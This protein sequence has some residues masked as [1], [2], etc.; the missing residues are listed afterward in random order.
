MI[1]LRRAPNSPE[2]DVCDERLVQYIANLYWRG[3]DELLGLLFDA[4][5]RREDVVDGAGEFY[6]NLLDRRTD[7]AMH[8][9][10]SIPAEKQ[11]IVCE[12][13]FVNDLRFDPPKLDRIGSKLQ[14]V[15]TGVALRCLNAIR[16]GKAK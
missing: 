7:I 6:A 5:Q 3:D 15:G 1:V 11:Q 14:Q 4:A 10:G 9:L 2:D 8:E 13:A 16:S 12:M